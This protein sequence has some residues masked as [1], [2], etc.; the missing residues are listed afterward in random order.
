MKFKDC[1]TIVKFD[2][3]INWYYSGKTR[4]NVFKHNSIHNIPKH[5]TKSKKRI[6]RQEALLLLISQKNKIDKEIA[7][8]PN[9][10]NRIKELEK[11]KA[12]IL[13]VISYYE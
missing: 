11:Q 3:G 6:N 12:S 10:I 4:G 13:R 8:I 2:E 5:Y 7:L 9:D 1:I